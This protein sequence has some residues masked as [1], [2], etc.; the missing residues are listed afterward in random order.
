MDYPMCD[1]GE[2]YGKHPPD[3]PVRKEIDRLAAEVL[4]LKIERIKAITLLKEMY[5]WTAYKDTV[6]AAQAKVLIDAIKVT[7]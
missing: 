5:D 3:C 7:A 6:W 1:C 4:H 2:F